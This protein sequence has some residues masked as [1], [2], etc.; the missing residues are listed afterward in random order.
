VV[1]LHHPL[2]FRWLYLGNVAVALASGA[3]FATPWK[4]GHVDHREN[5]SN[6][7]AAMS[8]SWLVVVRDRRLVL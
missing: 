3:F 6:A 2:I 4:Y 7:T 8:D 5:G 1:D